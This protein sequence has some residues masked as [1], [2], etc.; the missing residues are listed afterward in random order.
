MNFGELLHS[1]PIPTRIFRGSDVPISGV[2]E[3]SRLVYPGS[4]FVA[5]TGTRTQGIRFVHD[6]VSHG[7]A[8]LV[9]DNPDGLDLPPDF[10]FALCSNPS[11]ALGWLAQAMRNFPAKAMDLFA[12]TGTNG[13]TTTT[14]LLRSICHAAA[15]PCGLITTIQIDDGRQ[16][17]ENSMT[18]PDPVQLADLF[19]RMKANGA[20]I[21]AMEASSHALAQDRLAGLDFKVAMFS[22]LTQDHLDYHGTLENYAAAKSRLFESL[23]SGSFAAINADD[24]WSARM[25]QN[26]RARVISYGIEKPADVFC[27]I[28]RLDHSGMHLKIK[29]PDTGE[30]SINTPLV[31]RHN[32]QNI[33]CA[34]TAAWSAGLQL[35]RIIAGI[36]QMS[37]V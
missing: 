18:T 24:P 36:E 5:R 22:N 35:D 1:I 3:D 8:A 30:I 12:V 11:V 25:V 7:A 21:V 31:G 9:V 10:P 15:I 26:T 27:R 29:I 6:A 33:A 20:R 16:I 4:L 28:V 19:S 34:L 32:A 14:Y 17:G 13:K 23:G 37:H 2:T